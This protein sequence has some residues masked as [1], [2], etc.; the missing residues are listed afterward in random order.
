MKS[1]RCYCSCKQVGIA[2]TIFEQ[3]A[4]LYARPRDWSFG[5]YWAQNG[6]GSCLPDELHHLVKT[7][8]TDDTYDTDKTNTMPIYNGKSGELL[9][10]MSAES[11]KK[12]VA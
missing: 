9:T 12:E 8:Q 7:V 6:L 5:I 1:I 3:D 10:P 2:A 11:P 4:G